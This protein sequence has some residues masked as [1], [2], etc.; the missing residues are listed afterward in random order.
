MIP[1]LAIFV[2]KHAQ[3][4]VGAPYSCY[5]VSYVKASVNK[6]L[7]FTSTLHIADVEPYNGHIWLWR[8]LDDLWFRS[9]HNV[10]KDLVLLDDVFDVLWCEV[11][12]FIMLVIENVYYLQVGLRLWKVRDIN[13]YN[14]YAVYILDLILDDLQVRRRCDFACDNYNT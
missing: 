12:W 10:I 1:P 13:V 3:V 4:H 5:M 11:V 6:S 9:K 2:L 8:Y 7:S 14:I